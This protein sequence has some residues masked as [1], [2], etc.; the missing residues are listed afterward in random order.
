MTKRRLKYPE[1]AGASVSDK[2][3]K[4]YQVYRD[5]H[6]HMS[7]Y[8]A[9]KD[10][11]KKKNLEFTISPEDIVI[12]ETC[13][14]LGIPIV[15]KAGHGNPGGRMNSPSLDRIDNTKGYT[16]DNIQVISHQANSM[17]FTANKEELLLFAEW[18]RKTYV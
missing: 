13:P 6:P 9:A 8:S 17:K 1:L 15:V 16:K 12:P 5:K 14:I 11:A 4:Y 18:I 3:K 2:H 10:R 7:L